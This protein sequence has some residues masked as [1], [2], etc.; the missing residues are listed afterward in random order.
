M[1]TP[2]SIHHRARTAG[3]LERLL[4][5]A[6]LPG[7]LLFIAALLIP[8]PAG[9]AERHILILDWFP[10][11]DHVPLYV[12]REG[13]FFAREGLDIKLVAPADPNDPLKLVAAGKAAFAVNYQPNVIIA[14]S[15]GL[16]V[17]SIG[18][19]VEHP[20][21]SLAFLKRSGIRTPADLKGKR[22]G[23]SVQDLELA[24]LRALTASAGLKA[25]DYTTVNVNFN[26][27]PALLSGQVDAVMG[28][29]WNYE[30][31]ELELEGVPGGYFDL[32]QYG[33]PDYYELVLISND[34]FLASHRATAGALVRALQAAIDETRAQP[35]K[36]LALYFKANPEVRKD[37]DRLA[38]Q[39]VVDQFAHDQTQSR[40]KWERFVRFET[41]HGLIEK[42]PPTDELFTD[43]RR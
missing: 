27:T 20:L 12:A 21:S 41:A 15:R 4:R 6:L 34:G 22:I 10:N 35:E 8:A 33:V 42:A 17:R 43:P 36:A 30:L 39:R 2:S 23:Y 19:L 29:F 37:L 28:A 32:T 7:A 13:G 18:V 11:A 40:D 3:A 24:L 26:L 25:E 31:A 14:R 9:A 1:N 5:G 38:F 16:P